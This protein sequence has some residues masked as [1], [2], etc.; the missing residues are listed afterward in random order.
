MQVCQMNLLENEDS[1]SSS[2]DF[3]ETDIREINLSTWM[4]GI[5]YSQMMSINLVIMM[6]L[7]DNG[8]FFISKLISIES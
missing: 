3:L 6:L 2:K 4:L 5:L 8:V 7:F 1:L